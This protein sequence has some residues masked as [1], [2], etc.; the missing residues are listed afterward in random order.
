MNKNYDEDF[1]ILEKESSEGFSSIVIPYVIE[2]LKCKTVIDFGCG[3][4]QCLNNVK[5]CN[6]IE[7]VM[8]L[9]GQ[10][11]E[12]HLEIAQEE[13]YD[14][15]LTQDI[16]LKEKY[17]LAISLEVAEHLP[18]KSAKTFIRNLVKHSNVILFSAAIPHQ[19]GTYHVNEQYPSYWR[20]IFAAFDFSMCD[21]LRSHFWDDEKIEAFYRQNTFIY[22]RNDMQY[23]IL[24]KLTFEGKNI[25]V[26]HPYYWEIKNTYSYIF[27][28]ERVRHN[29]QIVVYG[30]G[31]V[32]KT[33]VNQLL[34][35]NYAE[36]VLWCDKA[37]DDYKDENISNPQ[38]IKKISFDNIIVAVEKEKAA[39]EI[40]DNLNKMGI[41]SEKIIWR[42][43]KFKNIY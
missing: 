25:D 32:G 11:V 38:K 39:L 24:E 13:F 8:G 21:C 43:P 1:Y 3:V 22:C 6:G 30:A 36:I 34:A 29:A 19:G 18:R 10:W 2:R 9:D 20:K 7:K 37:F 27:P 14:C 23:E 4:G 5:R 31:K 26:I 15:D 40:I 42:M 28:F 33:F 16:D 41:S 35:T 17:D 12:K